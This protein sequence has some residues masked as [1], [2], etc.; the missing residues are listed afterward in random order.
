MIL[1]RI[2]AAGF[3]CLNNLIIEEPGPRLLIVGSNGTGKSTLA[4]FV[5]AVL[6][7]MPGSKA[8][9]QWT[10][11]GETRR[12]YR[13]WDGRQMGGSLDIRLGDQLYRVEAWFGDAPRQDRCRVWCLSTG[14]ELVL[15]KGETPGERLMG[16]K[17]TVFQSTVL[18]GSGMLHPASVADRRGERR[19]FLSAAGQ[20][21]QMS[22]ASAD[23][24]TEARPAIEPDWEMGGSTAEEAVRLLRRQA[25]LLRS[26]RGDRGRIPELTAQLALLADEDRR[27]ADRDAEYAVWA[28]ST[29][30]LRRS[31]SDAEQQLAD[32]L[33]ADRAASEK[34]QEILA[35][36]LDAVQARRMPAAPASVDTGG[37][38]R[39]SAGRLPDLAAGLGALGVM[40]GIGFRVSGAAGVWPGVLIGGGL[41]AVLLSLLVRR[42]PRF[43]KRSAVDSETPDLTGNS[44][45]KPLPD[46]EQDLI[47]QYN[48]FGEQAAAR[49]T[50]VERLRARRDALAMDW[51]RAEGRRMGWDETAQ[52]VVPDDHREQRMHELSREI[53]AAERE[54]RAL[55]LA[56]EH[57]ETAAAELAA[58]Y[59]PEIRRYLQVWL[60]RVSGG[61]MTDGT[62]DDRLSVRAHFEDPAAPYYV[63]PEQLSTATREQTGFA[64]RLAMLDLSYES[65]REGAAAPLPIWMDM[66]FAGWDESRTAAAVDCLEWLA[67]KRGRQVILLTE[68][69]SLAAAAAARETG[70]DVV[71]LPEYPGTVS[72]QSDRL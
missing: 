39:K 8:G 40:T 37:S 14:A 66:P 68:N 3:G 22:G 50:E 27:R 5:L 20:D 25:A 38:G 42:R 48:R 49:R 4:A 36:G 62:V 51:S 61:R 21:I 67:G 23:A 41:L 2:H 55:K 19:A 69:R 16:L 15:G 29:E 13:P 32:C 59:F 17:Q 6:Y 63:D 64:L 65:G 31:L 33:A 30:A 34:E 12:A 46:M 9:A 44:D 7:G 60:P 56:V 54:Y 10:A 72:D 58:D 28:E 70:W 71:F 24:E 45:L 1:E 43:G 18:A 52:P 57:I 11:A 53:D 35:A 26:P 47:E